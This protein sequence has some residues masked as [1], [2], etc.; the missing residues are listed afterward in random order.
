MK[1]YKTTRCFNK[2]LTN[3]VDRPVVQASRAPSAVKD[4]GRGSLIDDKP[5]HAQRRKTA[6]DS[7]KGERSESI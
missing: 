4:N 5:R 6:K 3:L 1:V 7:S 2:N